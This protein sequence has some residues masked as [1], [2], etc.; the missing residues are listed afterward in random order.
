MWCWRVQY[1]LRK[2]DEYPRELY[3]ALQSL[4]GLSST[5][6]RR[7]PNGMG[8]RIH[9][10]SVFPPWMRALLDMPANRW[11]SSVSSARSKSPTNRMSY[12]CRP[13]KERTSQNDFIGHYSSPAAFRGAMYS[14]QCLRCRIRL[15]P[16]DIRIQLIREPHS[17]ISFAV[18]KQGR[19][20]RFMYVF[21]HKLKITQN[22]NLIK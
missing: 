7:H 12:S 21:P 8:E 3:N 5:N 17:T 1:I 15:G 13:L 9:L 6:C 10:I 11:R 19:V 4:F 2:N 20:D 14:F 22:M 18:M 16:S